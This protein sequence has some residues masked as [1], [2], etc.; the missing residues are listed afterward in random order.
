MSLARAYALA[1]VLA[2]L[3]ARREDL[4]PLVQARVD[5]FG[6]RLDVAFLL[7]DA[8][9]LG[10]QRQQVDGTAVIRIE[11]STTLSLSTRQALR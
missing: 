7:A 10:A 3:T 1:H 11:E 2:R 9:L 5:G 8:L 4:L 6:L